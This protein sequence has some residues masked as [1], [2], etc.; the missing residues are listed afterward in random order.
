MIGRLPAMPM[1]IITVASEFDLWA[2]WNILPK[3][4]FRFGGGYYLT[5]DW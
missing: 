5:G 2:Q 1:V 3:L 4:W